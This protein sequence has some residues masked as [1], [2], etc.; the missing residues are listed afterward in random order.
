MINN[1]VRSVRIVGIDPGLE[2]T[3]YGCITSSDAQTVLIEAGVIRTKK[4]HDLVNRLYE[5]YF[6]F[7]QVLADFNPDVVAIEE[8]YAHY[9][10]PRTA[11]IMGHARGALLLA[12]GQRSI[13]VQSYSANRIK[14]SLTGNG[15]AAKEQMQRMIMNML[16]LDQPPSPP[17]VADAIAVALCHCNTVNSRFCGIPHCGI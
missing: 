12:A 14:K 8:L 17:D 2:I 10:H 4:S 7:S 11:I 16:K 3:G 9:N 13:P 1:G 15:H 5:L 6:Q